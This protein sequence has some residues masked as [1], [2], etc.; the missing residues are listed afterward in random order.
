MWLSP[1]WWCIHPHSFRSIELSQFAQGDRAV[2]M[3]FTPILKVE[4]WKH[5]KATYRVNNVV[6]Y[7]YT[8][9]ITLVRC[10]VNRIEDNGKL[11]NITHYKIGRY[12]SVFYL[13]AIEKRFIS[14]QSFV[15][16]NHKD[17]QHLVWRYQK[18][19]QKKIRRSKFNVLVP[20][21]GL[22]EVISIRTQRYHGRISAERFQKEDTTPET[23]C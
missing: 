1:C 22:T 15:K 10:T 9:Q 21:F 17:Q 16:W 6:S 20:Q 4:F 7:I 19:S 14:E 5:N 2:S 18:S 13:L 12:Y 23:I 8:V 11:R 3:Y